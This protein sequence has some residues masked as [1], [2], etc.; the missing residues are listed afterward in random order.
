MMIDLTCQ[1]CEASFEI[2]ATDLIEGSERI[3]CPNCDA[4]AP[5]PLV[6]DVGNALG[7]LCKSVA[8][9]RAR[10]GVSLAVETDD[11]PPPYDAEDEEDEDE[12]DDDEALL[13]D[14]DE[15]DDDEDS[16]PEDEEDVR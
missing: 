2:D 11:L 9:L 5:Q 4:K 15:D 13:D 1:K 6:D 7:E 3:K 14:P 10:F 8:A 16:E 12:D